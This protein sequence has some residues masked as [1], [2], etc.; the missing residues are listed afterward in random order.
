MMQNHRPGPPATMDHRFE[1]KQILKREMSQRESSLFE[2]WAP[3]AM[4]SNMPSVN[5]QH[6]VQQQQDLAVPK[7]HSTTPKRLN[8]TPKIQQTVP[9]KQDTVPKFDSM[10]KRSETTPR[11][12]DYSRARSKRSSS[13]FDE[14]KASA[15]QNDPLNNTSAATEIKKE[16]TKVLS[17]KTVGGGENAEAKPHSQPVKNQNTLSHSQKSLETSIS[18]TGP[19]NQPPNKSGNI[20]TGNTSAS[21]NHL[22]PKPVNRV[23]SKPVYPKVTVERKPDR[24]GY[25]AP[26]GFF[27]HKIELARLSDGVRTRSKDRVIFRPSFLEN[28]W[29]DM[30]AVRIE[31]LAFY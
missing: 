25:T 14:W 29:K 12:Q 1:P 30:K 27:I 20:T 8:S 17:S 28:P 4:R 19:K 31:S 22:A 16:D 24:E 5:Q 26:N 9:R 11:N 23:V 3:E 15:M 13:M 18:T 6:N 10:P 2:E 21:S 7:T